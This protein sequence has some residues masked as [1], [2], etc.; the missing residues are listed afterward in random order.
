MTKT[1][2]SYKCED[3]ILEEDGDDERADERADNQRLPSKKSASHEC[4]VYVWNVMSSVSL[5]MSDKGSLRKD[6]P[7]G[8]RDPV[9]RKL[10]EVHDLAEEKNIDEAITKELGEA[11]GIAER[12]ELYIDKHCSIESDTLREIRIFT[13]QKDWTEPEKQGLCGRKVAGMMTGKVEG[14]FLK[15]LVS[16]QQAKRILDVGMFTGYSALAMAEAI[17]PEGVVIT[18]DTEQYLE[19]INRKKLDESPHGQKIDIRIGH[20]KKTML[21]LADEGQKFDFILW[22]QTKNPT[23]TTTTSSWIKVCWL[24]MARLPLTTLFVEGHPT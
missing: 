13:Q 10:R 17:P 6:A 8:R 2:G 19:Q 21:S 4:I 9:Y 3:S 22:T 14:E 24:R 7:V 18:C 1:R 23:L 20:A 11:I 16:M 12:R 5:M 15:F